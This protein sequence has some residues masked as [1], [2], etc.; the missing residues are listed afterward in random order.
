MKINAKPKVNEKIHFDDFCSIKGLSDLQIDLFVNFIENNFP[1]GTLSSAHVYEWWNGYYEDSVDESRKGSFNEADE[2][3]VTVTDSD[4]NQAVLEISK[5]DSG[6]WVEKC[7]DKDLNF[8]WEKQSYRGYM[9]PEE[10]MQW[11]RVDF[12]SVRLGDPFGNPS[13]SKY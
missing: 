11:L 13:F 9:K 1:V 5:A 2:F 4:G 12:P 7:L 10:I 8:K 3:V 6:R